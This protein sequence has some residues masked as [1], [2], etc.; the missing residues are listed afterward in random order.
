MTRTWS[1]GT[2]W[3]LLGCAI[4]CGGAS[5]TRTP[6]ASGWQHDGGRSIALV[7]ERV[8]NAPLPDGKGVAVG[9][10]AD[11]LVGIALDG[12]GRWEKEIALDARPALSGQVLVGTG[13]GRVFCLEAATGR[14][15]WQLPSGGKSVRGAGDDGKTTVVSLGNRAGG[16][17]HFLAVDRGGKVLLELSPEVEIGVPG[18]L[19]GAA[20]VP[21]GNQY[22]SAIDLETGD[23]IGR[24]LTRT[25]VTRTKAVG[26]TLYFG[27]SALIAFDQN[28]VK[29]AQNQANQITLPQRELPGTPAWHR[30]G[31]SVAPRNANA[32]DKVTLS[33]RPEL[34]PK[35]LSIDG[36]RFVATYFR[37][38]VGLNAKDGAVRWVR[39]HPSDVL[40]TGA[41]R[42]GFALCEAQGNVRLIAAR[43]GG[44]AGKVSFGKPLTA[45]VIDAGSFAVPAGRDAVPLAQQIAEAISVRETDMLSIQRFLIRELASDPDPSVTKT[46]LGVASDARTAEPMLED[47]RRTL[48]A[49]RSGADHMLEALERRFDFLDDVLRPPPVG[50]LADALAAMNEKRAAPLLAAHLNE[51]TA[52]TDD[53]RRAAKALETLAGAAELPEIRTFFTL[54]RATADDEN[55]VGAV[56]S[57]ARVLTRI[58]GDVEL[59]LV[60]QAARDPLTQPQIKQGLTTMAGKGS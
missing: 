23:E 24:L 45:C 5:G 50:P 48:A 35:G 32:H 28:A 38:T 58:G 51:P 41:A 30:S 10:T 3:L 9:V 14:E 46:L 53:V 18:V 7:Q 55:M 17:S 40:A 39:T 31:T 57:A 22:V 16:G 43:D 44:D 42:G 37:I 54:Y 56:L 11:G 2:G 33:A 20:F 4:A 29:A 59:D 8:K 36:E 19:D 47:S 6:F 25:V 60:K 49:R 34:G 26:G 13:N 1:V 52:T 15:L 12:T 27:E 21:W